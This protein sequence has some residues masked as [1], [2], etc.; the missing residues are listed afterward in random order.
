MDEEIGQNNGISNR[1]LELSSFEL[2]IPNDTST[3]LRQNLIGCSTLS[4]EWLVPN[5][6]L[7]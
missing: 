1:A 4:Q 6:S 7:H 5:I 3:T 2:E